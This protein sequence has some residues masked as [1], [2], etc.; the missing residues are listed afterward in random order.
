MDGM[1]LTTKEAAKRLR[2][3][4]ATLKNWRVSGAGPRYLKFGRKVLYP[5]AEID[6]WEKAKLRVA[7]NALIKD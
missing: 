2:L 4:E 6:A 5:L 3:A 1:H 7:T